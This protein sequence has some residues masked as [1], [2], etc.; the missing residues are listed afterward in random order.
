MRYAL[1][2]LIKTPR[3]TLL[4]TLTLAL[5]IGAATALFSVVY[6][7]LLRPLP[8]KDPA[9]LVVVLETSMRRG[10]AVPVAPGNFF[11]WLLQSRAA[12]HDDGRGTNGRRRRARRRAP[13]G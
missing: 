13:A 12:L 4:A 2:T 5:G 1:R 6:G 8:Y 3:F 11:D 10:G 9:R 7:V